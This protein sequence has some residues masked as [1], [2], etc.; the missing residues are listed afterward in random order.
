M[1]NLILIGMPGCGKST[2][3]VLL[4]K[5][6]GMGFIDTDLMIQLTRKETLQTLLDKY[7]TERFREFEEEAL[8]LAAAA[9]NT[10]IATG[11]SAVFCERGM[12]ALTKS[13]LC[14]YFAVDCGELERRITNITTRGIAAAAGMTI[15]DIFAERK[16]LYERYADLTVDAG[17]GGLEENIAAATAAISAYRADAEKGAPPT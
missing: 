3:G 17:A 2:C 15:A 6:L 4:A 10:V 16:P 12:A 5:T 1:T 14:L 13:G 8:I 9:E 11:G 7:G